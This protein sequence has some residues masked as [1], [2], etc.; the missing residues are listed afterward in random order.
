MTL[1]FGNGTDGTL[2]RDSS[3]T[4]LYFGVGDTGTYFPLSPYTY[5]GASAYTPPTAPDTA[6]SD[7]TAQTAT[8]RIK[9]SAGQII[10][11][12]VPGGSSITAIQLIDGNLTSGNRVM[13][14]VSGIVAPQTI[15]A[16]DLV[17]A[18][19]HPVFVNGLRMVQTGAGNSTWVTQ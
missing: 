9:S 2:L 11:I 15:T 10:S 16:A 6:Q 18:S 14:T 7:T 3:D 17:T 4:R 1:Y 13:G 12:T 8:G 5:F 19:I